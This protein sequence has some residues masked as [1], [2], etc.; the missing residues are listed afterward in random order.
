M[1][2]HVPEDLSEGINI[3][4]SDI[5]QPPVSIIQRPAPVTLREGPSPEIEEIQ[6]P[7]PEIDGLLKITFYP[8]D[9]EGYIEIK[10]QPEIREAELKEFIPV[11]L[12]NREKDMMVE[13]NPIHIGE[14]A[15]F[16]V[17]TKIDYSIG[18][19]WKGKTYEVPLK[20]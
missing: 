1:K 12:I 4:V 6:I 11:I 14:I 2:I 20:F 5:L 9:N 16:I 19:Q 13:R 18:I 17:S 3:I 8:S 15:T 7:I 10:V